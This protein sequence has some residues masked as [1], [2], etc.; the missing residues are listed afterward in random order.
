MRVACL[1]L[2]CLVPA[3]GA[4]CDE[5]AG[6]RTVIGTIDPK[7]H[8]YMY[9][10]HNPSSSNVGEY[11]RNEA[12]SDCVSKGGNLAAVRNAEE[13]GNI[14][15]MCSTF[16]CWI[17]LNDIASERGR[18]IDLWQSPNGAISR[19]HTCSGGSECSNG[20]WTYQAWS[21]GEPNNCC[22]SGE[23]CGE[24]WNHG[25]GVGTVRGFYVELE[26]NTQ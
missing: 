7:E 21:R 9:K 2:V 25:S 5:D 23:D 12:E 3:F 10:D 15:G 6:W 19:G 11:S 8:C 13:N 14:M 17:G 16:R 22:W 1:L 4:I 24:M 26:H 18:S 20:K